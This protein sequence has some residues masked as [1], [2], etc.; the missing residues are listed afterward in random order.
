MHSGKIPVSTMTDT[1]TL[2]QQLWDLQT[3]L[4]CTH[5]QLLERDREVERLKSMAGKAC[6]DAA[7]ALEIANTQAAKVSRS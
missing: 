5:A 6:T 1:T 3:Q 4:E 2:E 7:E